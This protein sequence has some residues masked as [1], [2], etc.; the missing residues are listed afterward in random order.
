MD[1]SKQ[2]SHPQIVLVSVIMIVTMVQTLVSNKLDT[3]W[4]IHADKE[5]GAVEIETC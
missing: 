2:Q 5:D 3:G 1:F 4:G